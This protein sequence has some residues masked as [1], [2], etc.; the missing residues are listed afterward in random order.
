MLRRRIVITGLGAAFP[1]CLMIASHSLL[2]QAAKEA[3]SGYRT[4]QDRARVASTL[5]DESRDARQKPE[6]LVASLS[7]KPGMTVADVGTGAGY[8]L[9]YLSRSVGPKGKVLAQDIFPDFLE[10]ARGKAKQD[11]LTNV[12]F[13][14][15]DTRSAK[16]PDAS[17]DLILV[18]D[19][20]HHF[21][22]PAEMLAS[23]KRALKQGGTLAI[24]EY[25]KSAE[26]MP[27]GRALTHIRLPKDGFVREIEG[28]G[29]RLVSSKDHIPN[30]Q[31]IGLFQAK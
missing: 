31:W 19:A 27:K 25:H 10:R 12:E 28:H 24:V 13:F 8:M 16:L 15:G 22:Y 18:L 5:V 11:G 20:Y 26:A 2:A 21:D 17:A 7:L 1:V 30:A 6:E 29:F 4:E 9:P 3:N 23:L 14:L